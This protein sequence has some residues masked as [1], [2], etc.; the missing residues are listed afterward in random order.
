[1]SGSGSGLNTSRL[2]RLLTLIAFVTAVFLLTAAQ[3]LSDALFSIAVV[4]VG[5]VALVT[6][7]LGFVIALASDPTDPGDSVGGG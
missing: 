5:S 1:M 6:A 7:I 2:V 3:V 4:A